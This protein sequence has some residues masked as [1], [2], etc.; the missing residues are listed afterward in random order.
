MTVGTKVPKIKLPIA[1]S[2]RERAIFGSILER[3]CTL[4]MEETAATG[5]NQVKHKNTVID[6]MMISLTTRSRPRILTLSHRTSLGSQA[7][8]ARQL[9]GSGLTAI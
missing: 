3:D 5:K 8:L 9:K 6:Q 2:S 1:L 4:N 7:I